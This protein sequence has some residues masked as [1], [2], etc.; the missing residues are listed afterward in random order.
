MLN[1]YG[2]YYLASGDSAQAIPFLEMSVFLYPEQPEI[3]GI[4]EQAKGQ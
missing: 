3:K 4:L 1:V 2:S